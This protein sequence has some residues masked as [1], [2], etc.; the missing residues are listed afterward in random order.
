MYVHST[1][2]GN[3]ILPAKVPIVCIPTSLSAGEYTPNAGATDDETHHKHSVHHKPI[4][5]R[6][7]VLDLELLRTIPERIWLSTE[8]RAVDHLVEAICSL[9]FTCEGDENAERGLRKL[10][11]GLL[12]NKEKP[13][14]LEPRLQC[15]LGAVDAIA[16]ALLKVPMVYVASGCV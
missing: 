4:G 11:P 14:E 5:L 2:I 15:Q 1:T 6:L 9:K 10:L 16:S 3:P 7:I 13:D 8:I 12:Q